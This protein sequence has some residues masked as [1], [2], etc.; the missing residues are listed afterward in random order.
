MKDLIMMSLNL[1]PKYAFTSYESFFSVCVN[2][3]YISVQ[4]YTTA[5]LDHHKW[6]IYFAFSMFYK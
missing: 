5:R 1:M 6:K 2:M 4:K 3:N